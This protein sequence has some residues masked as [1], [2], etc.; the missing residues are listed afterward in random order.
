V[1]PVKV[2]FG[3]EPAMANYFGLRSFAKVT[4]FMMLKWTNWLLS[5]FK[6]LELEKPIK[7]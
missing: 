1:G 3:Q 7:N 5:S 2:R 4:E 6:G